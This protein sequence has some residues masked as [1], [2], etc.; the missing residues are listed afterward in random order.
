NDDDSA[1]IA[2]RPD[3]SANLAPGSYRYRLIFRIDN[4]DEVDT[5]AI[6]A[7]VGTDDGTG[8]VF[9]N[10]ISIPFGGS[11]FG[12]FTPL[13]IPPGSGFVAGL[14]TL[15]FVVNNGGADIN[16]SGLR[17]DDIVLSGVT[18]IDQPELTVTLSG[19]MIRIAWPV[20]ATEF[21][22][23]QTS[24]LP[25]GWTDSTLTV[26]VEGNE[27]VVTLEPDAGAL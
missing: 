25:G 8:G 18:V 23:Q 22:L 4:P 10:G 24:A 17:V 15:D 1:W 3:N 14:H 20:T 19:S 9:L 6:T 12:A 11:G 13:D 16:P 26:T 2:P 27:N 7:N 5:A 21:R